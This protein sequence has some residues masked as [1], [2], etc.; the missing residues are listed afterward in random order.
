MT[1]EVAARVFEPFYTTRPGGEGTGLGL[2]MVHGF[3]RQSGGGVRVASSPGHGTTFS[4]V[5]RSRPAAG[6]RPRQVIRG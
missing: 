3:L 2:A 5:L 6:A 4:S 1:P